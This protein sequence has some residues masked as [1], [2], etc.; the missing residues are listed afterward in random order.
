ME[1]VLKNKLHFFF[2]FFSLI[3]Y[4]HI[5]WSYDPLQ[6]ESQQNEIPEPLKDVG[7]KE[8]LGLDLSRMNLKFTD[9]DGKVRPLSYWLNQGRPII[10]SL[11]YFNC[12]S[13][14][15]LHLNGVFEGLEKL[16]FMPGKDYT[17]LA[18][19]FALGE[20]YDLAA[21][22]KVTYLE[23]YKLPQESGGVHFLTGEESDVK[24]LAESVG[25]TY[26][27]DESS[28]EWAHASAAILITPEGVISRYLH[29]VH[30]EPKTFRLSL[31]EASK[32]MIGDIIDQVVL[33]S[34]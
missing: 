6:Y 27:W 4:G 28:K 23:R 12:P 11:V 15:S 8:N 29:G 13:L 33:F 34:L 14:C 19:S 5:A 24:K 26:K 21:A 31:V 1:R 18:L 22:K 10:L 20:T 30:F 3:A 2:F 25:F 9:D 32:G 7:I 17:L 16:S